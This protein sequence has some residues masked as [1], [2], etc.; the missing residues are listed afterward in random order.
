MPYAASISERRLWQYLLARQTCG[1]SASKQQPPV[2]VRDGC[3]TVVESV[4]LLSYFILKYFIT[5]VV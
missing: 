1:N 2:A 5:I 4:A 3:G